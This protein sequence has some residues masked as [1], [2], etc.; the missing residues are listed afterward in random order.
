MLIKIVP[1]LFLRNSYL[2]FMW[3]TT[4]KIILKKLWN[5][6]RIISNT[7]EGLSKFSG[8]SRTWYGL[9]GKQF[10]YIYQYNTHARGHTYMQP[11]HTHIFWFNN[12]RILQLRIYFIYYKIC[13]NTILRVLIKARNWKQPKCPSVGYWLT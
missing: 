2:K 13:T 8:V 12:S 3:K 5:L 9:F 4:Y 7:G 6:R 1:K 10:V 11:P